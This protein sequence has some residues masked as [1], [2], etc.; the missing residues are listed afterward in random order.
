MAAYKITAINYMLRLFI[1]TKT[2]ISVF[3]PVYSMVLFIRSARA[4]FPKTSS[5][6]FQFPLFAAYGND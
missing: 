5:P 6:G 1:P 3:Y 2:L 4:S